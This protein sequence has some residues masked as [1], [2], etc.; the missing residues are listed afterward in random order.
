MNY[1]KLIKNNIL[2]ILTLLLLFF[3]PLYPKIPLVDVENTWVYVRFE[4]LIVAATLTLWIFLILFKKV[5]LKTPLTVPIFFFWLIGAIS[6][7]HGVLILFPTL[8][9]V[10]SNVAF[11]SLIRRVEYLS[12]FFVAYAS[13]KDKKFINLV[14]ATLTVTVLLII[15]YGF[16]QKLFGFPAFLT[17][18]EEFAKGVPLRISQLGRVPST[19]A[20]HY[21]LAAYLVLVIPIFVSLFFGVKNLLLKALFSVT[22]VLG[23]VLLLMTVSRVSFFVLIFSLLILLIAQRKKIIIFSLAILVLGLLIVSPSLVKRFGSTLTDVNVLINTRTG[24]AISEVKEFPKEYFRDKTIIKDNAQLKEEKASGSANILLYED[25]PDKV[26]FLV[27]ANTST[28]ENLPQ[29]TGYV[30][31]ELSPVLKRS[32]MYFAEKKDESSGATEVHAYLGNFLVK[33]A[34][35]Y[36]LSFTTRFQGEWPRTIDA[37]KRNIF[38]GSGYGSVSLAVDNNYLRILGESG[39]LG[40]GAFIAILLSAGIFI[41]KT[42]SKVDSPIVKSF[43]LGFLTGALGLLLN[44]IL[45]DVFEASKVAFSFW[46]LLGVTLGILH[47]YARDA[48]LKISEDLKKILFSRFAVAVYLFIIT[49]ILF[50]PL[51]SNYFTGDDFT[52]LRWAA[53]TKDNFLSYFTS[54]EGFFYRPGAR[55]YFLLMYKLFWLNQTFYHLTSIILHFGVSLLIFIV[56]GKI[57]KRHLPAVLAAI[58]F[59]VLSGHHEAVFWI[60]STGFLF[61][62]F[63]ALL[64]LLFYILFKEKAKN[65]YLYLT[66][67]TIVLGLLFHELGIVAPLILIAYDFVFNY[68]FRAI[69]KKIHLALIIPLIPYL[70]LRIVSQSHWFSGDYSY[71]LFKLPFN[72]VGNTL[73]YFVLDL[74]GPQSLGF[75]ESL[76]NLLRGNLLFAVVGSSVLVFVAVWTGRLMLRKLNLEDKKIVIFGILFFILSLLPFLGLGNITSRYSYLSSIGFAIVFALFLEKAVSYVRTLTDKYTFS[77]VIGLISIMFLSFQ[78]FQLQNI[79]SDWKGGGERVKKFLTSFEDVFLITQYGTYSQ[80]DDKKHTSYY[81]VDVPIRVGEAWIFPVGISDALW[82]ALKNKNFTVDTFA[83]V[84]DALFKQDSNPDADVFIFE[85]DGSVR[86]VFKINNNIMIFPKKD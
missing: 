1:F 43:V 30:N 61:T 56:L 83:N 47:L 32:D 24:E 40:F 80:Y 13:V 55:I 42:Y 41:K 23:F 34:R 46:I 67:A 69:F 29:G 64:S 38:I 48:S 7:F 33:R 31:L 79:H 45:I 21:D 71:N 20:G 12:L 60:S 75:Y 72:V 54:S 11:L 77:I 44:A 22:S 52:W 25:I 82:F 58:L 8:P 35:A 51:Y 85:K 36:D 9:N 5:K 14:I 86:K 66:I 73:G 28:G 27:P 50:S 63:F 57:L 3:I 15:F 19:F 62:S 68:D 2:S 70:F 39:L 10:F 17:G 6:T 37:F 76:R 81:F 26:E 53:Q 49:I 74:F 4:D 16:G 65:A 78:L 59:L 84:S 18:N